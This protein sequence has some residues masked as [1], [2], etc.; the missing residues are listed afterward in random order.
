MNTYDKCACSGSGYCD[1]S[2]IYSFTFQF[3]GAWSI[4]C[5]AK[6]KKPIPWWRDWL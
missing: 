1:P 5:G 6:P 3:M 4:L 2:A